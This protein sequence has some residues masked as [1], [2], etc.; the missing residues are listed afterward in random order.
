MP[1]SINRAPEVFET[2]VTVRGNAR[3]EDTGAVKLPS[4]TTEQRP[5]VGENALVRFNETLGDYEVWRG[6]KWD[7][8][9]TKTTVDEINTKIAEVEDAAFIN[10]LL[11]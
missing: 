10:A 2:G 7:P 6:G 3:F 5:G 9:T 8:I 4:G 11:F 1:A